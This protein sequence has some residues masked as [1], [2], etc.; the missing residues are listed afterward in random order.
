MTIDYATLAE[1]WRSLGL[2]TWADTIESLTRSRMSSSTHGD[3]EQ[4]REVLAS[5]PQIDSDPVE[6]RA[7]LLQLSPWL[8]GPFDVGGFVIDTVWRRILIWVLVCD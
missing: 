1:C 8:N 4:W 3:F 6:T 7:A 5:L 2:E